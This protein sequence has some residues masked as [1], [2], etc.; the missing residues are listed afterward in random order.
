M[1]LKEKVKDILASIL[2]YG[3]LVWFSMTIA[4][5]VAGFIWA[6]YFYTQ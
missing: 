2:Y 1:I 3:L 6:I 4:G 5:L